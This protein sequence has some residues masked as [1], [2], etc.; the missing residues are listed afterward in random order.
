[1]YLFGPITAD[2]LVGG[3]DC[4]SGRKCKNPGDGE[5]CQSQA[6]ERGFIF[7]VVVEV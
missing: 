3:G 5:S 1:M 4:Q 2:S 6:G 7:K